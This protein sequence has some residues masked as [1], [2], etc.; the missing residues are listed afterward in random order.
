LAK[1]KGCSRKV[2]TLKHRQAG[3]C[4][5]ASKCDTCEEFLCLDCDRLK[6]CSVCHMST[7]SSA[8]C[9][10]N[11]SSKSRGGKQPKQPKNPVQISFQ[12]HMCVAPEP[13][14]LRAAK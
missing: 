7:C 11:C 9:G 4:G 3:S 2:C 12:K 5:S 13:Y 1:C 10:C 8:E 14:R 6:T